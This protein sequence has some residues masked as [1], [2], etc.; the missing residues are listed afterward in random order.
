MGLQARVPMHV[1]ERANAAAD[2]LGISLGLYLEQLVTRDQLD[3]HG[4]SLWA[5]DAGIAP[6]NE[7]DQALPGMTVSAA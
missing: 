1:R 3:E 4:R 7:H 5:G 6:K 2:A